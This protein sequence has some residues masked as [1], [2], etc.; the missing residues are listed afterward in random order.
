MTCCVFF[1]YFLYVFYFSIFYFLSFFFL[2]DWLKDKLQRAH[3]TAR[4]GPHSER[5]SFPSLLS[6]WTTI[7]SIQERR[8]RHTLEIVV[9]YFQSLWLLVPI[10]TGFFFSKKFSS[11]IGHIF[12]TIFKIEHHRFDL[13]IK[14]L[15]KV[16]IDTQSKFLF[17]LYAAAKENSNIG[18]PVLFFFHFPPVGR[19]PNTNNKRR[20]DFL[21]F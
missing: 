14:S 5:V 9:F 19:K 11:R 12:T 6:S 4:P 18:L 13:W 21:S 2:L 10:R 15:F 3:Q 7:G 16:W 1:F 8:E 20:T 17:W